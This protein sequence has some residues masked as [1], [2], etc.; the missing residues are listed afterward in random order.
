MDI[1]NTVNSKEETK[2]KIAK[3]DHF[4]RSAAGKKEVF[5]R[6]II[7]IADKKQEIMQLKSS[8]NFILQ[9][10]LLPRSYILNG[11]DGFQKRN[12]HL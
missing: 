10:L 2:Q 3:L 12:N 7:K 9:S 8:L 6:N 11:K 4:V 5:N 1:H